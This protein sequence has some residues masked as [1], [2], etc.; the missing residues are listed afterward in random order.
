MSEIGFDPRAALSAGEQAVA[1]AR[2]EEDDY[3]LA[4]A[5]NNLG[6]AT[7]ALGENGTGG[8]LL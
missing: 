7:R 3:A 5:L 2:E 4:I 1:F 8:G 6:E